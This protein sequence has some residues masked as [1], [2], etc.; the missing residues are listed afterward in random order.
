M[1][2]KLRRARADL[3][4]MNALF[5]A[6]ERIAHGDGID[7]PGAEHLLLAALDLDDGARP[8]SVRGAASRARSVGVDLRSRIA[9]TST[10]KAGRRQR[11]LR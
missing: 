5:P 2:D 10:R 7:Q 11:G 3:T 9:H 1:F 8:N 4:T 6:A